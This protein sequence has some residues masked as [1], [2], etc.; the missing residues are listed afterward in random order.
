MVSCAFCKGDTLLFAVDEV[1]L[2]LLW[3]GGGG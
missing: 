1:G 3:G 2:M